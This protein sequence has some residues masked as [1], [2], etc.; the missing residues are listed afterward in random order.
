M[1]KIA[2]GIIIKDDSELEILQRA[3]GSVIKYVDAIYITA[4][5]TPNYKIQ[6]FCKQV[7]AHYSFFK[8][9]KDFSKARNYNMSQISPEYDWYFWMD[10]DD[11]VQGAK[12]FQ[13]AIALAEA[14]NIKAIFARYLYQ[15][16]LDEKGKIK[17]ILIEHLRE[18]L[19]KN[20][21][22]FEWVAPIHETLIEKVPTGKTDF[23][24]FSVVHLMQPN[25]ME[26]SMWR[27]IGILEQNI[28][29]NPQDPRPIYYLAKA[30]FD[31]RL[32]ELLYE[33]AGEGSESICIMLIKQ[34][35][36][37]SGWA[38]ER[39]QA[40]EYLSMIY[41]EQNN[42]KA[43]IDC[44]MSALKEDPKFTSVYIQIA[45]SY[46]M[47][48]D[49]EKAMHWIKLAGNVDIPKTTLV[50]NPRDYKT[51]ILEALFHIY[52]NTGKLE[53]CLKVAT[54]LNEML[55]NDLNAGRV[56]DVGDLKARNDLAHYI[57]KLAHH[58]NK[59]GQTQQ[60]EN[61]VF[62]IPEEIAGEPAMINLRNQFSKPRVWEDNEI[63]IYCG[64]GFEQ[65]SWKSVAKGVGG[66]EEAVIHMSRE[67][68]KLGWRVYVFGDPQG[69]AGV[70]DGVAWLPYY[71]INWRDEFNILI[72]WRNIGIFDVPNLKAK[73]S[74]LWNHDLQNNLTYTPERVNKMT[75]AFFLSKYHR[76][77][78]PSL[79][80]SK[81]MITSNGI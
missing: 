23:Q 54:D 1:A 19:V 73:R 60:L 61:L 46:V 43:A 74:Y 40:W 7:G 26:K 71:H 72:G 31:T 35:L 80:E 75:K 29:D 18:R 66:S 62:S 68:A 57:V 8:W 47:L 10:T 42:F 65:W 67:L 11:V 64:G 22:T 59:T 79:D 49:W 38:E 32:P 21:G 58:L 4:T 52:L 13:D 77:N 44:L 48:K 5:T 6:K 3:V 9:V 34:Y 28:M 56:R 16:E 51:M 24:G 50:I 30:Y 70:H 14:N 39:S 15:V 76:D 2:V 20:D 55:P 53:E 37:M 41:R 25:Q 36:D 33:P 63:A 27:N 69:D 78:V 12:A 17:N 81:V 45:L